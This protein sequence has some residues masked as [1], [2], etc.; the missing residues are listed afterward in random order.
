MLQLQEH[1]TMYFFFV[2]AESL[3]TLSIHILAL[4]SPGLHFQWYRLAL[5]AGAFPST[6][7]DQLVF[8]RVTWCKYNKGCIS[9]IPLPMLI[10]GLGSFHL[11]DVF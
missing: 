7:E 2:K 9:S 3:E 11:Q 1:N 5:T 4:K 8:D 10:T 6:T